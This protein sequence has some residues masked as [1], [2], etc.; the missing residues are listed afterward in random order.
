MNHIFD[1][2]TDFIFVEDDPCQADIILIPGGSYPEVMHKACELFLTGYGKY[3]LPSGSYNPRLPTNQTEFDFFQQIALSQGIA[4]SKI[5]RE[6]KATNTLENALFSHAVL[7]KQA[8]KIHKGILV[9]KNYH[10]RRA[11]M[12]YQYV[13]GKDVQFVVV[14]TVDSRGL[15]K[16]NW[17]IE[18]QN[19]SMVLEEVKKIGQYFQELAYNDLR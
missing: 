11:L 18:S 10:A 16:Y 8:I 2:I 3:L 9:C 13:F 5:L 7:E 19:R 12:S 15:Y 4:S 1:G 17:F 6:D 14:P